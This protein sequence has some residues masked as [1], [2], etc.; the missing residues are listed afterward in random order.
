MM[1][2]PPH[3]LD[4]SLVE[5][6][7]TGRID[8]GQLQT[9]KIIQLG[10][11]RRHVRRFNLENLEVRQAVEQRPQRACRSL[12]QAVY[13][14][15]IRFGHYEGRRTPAAWWPGEQPDDLVM[16]AVGAKKEGDE[17]ARVQIDFSGQ[18]RLRP[19]TTASTV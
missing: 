14:P 12:A 8:E 15:A 3:R 9:T 17:S 10:P 11:Y 16:K 6:D 2:R 1:V 13:E 7:E 18:G 4:L 19:W 5:P